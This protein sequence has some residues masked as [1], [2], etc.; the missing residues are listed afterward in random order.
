MVS[1]IHHKWTEG[2]INWLWREVKDVEEL[3][4]DVRTEA[5]GWVRTML[6]LSMEYGLKAYVGADRYQRADSRNTYRN[7]YYERD[8]ET[9]LGLIKDI[10]VPRA[11]NGGYRPTE[12]FQRYKRRQEGVNR[13]LREMFLGGISTRR[14]GEVLETLLGYRLSA[15]TVSQATKEL[16]GEIRKYHNRPLTERYKF[17]LLDGVVLRIKGPERYR[18]RVILCAYGITASRRR[19]LIDFMP[20]RGETEAEWSSFLNSLYRR[21]L[22]GEGLEL[23]VIDGG[24]GLV[25]ALDMV[26]PFIPRQRC[27]V[28]KLRNIANYVRRKDRKEVLAGA[29]K[30]YQAD[31]K[32][33]S[34][35]KYRQWANR[36]RGPYPKA[37]DC[38][39]KDLEALLRF[40]DFS[41]EYR[42]T[43]RTT[44]PIER[45]FRE[46][47]RRTRPISCFNDTRSCERIV[48]GVFSYL[49]KK[50]KAH[51]IKDFNFTQ[52]S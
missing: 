3:W 40:L 4:G 52:F 18:K 51:P 24:R 12:V 37:V 49:N 6:G 33:E 23:I 11:R 26:Y 45:A 31:N 5:L 36:W 10:A 46:V 20:A 44:N 27:W 32:Q 28:H 14:V 22:K 2:S 30:I 9:E 47:R 17:L 19:E 7:G 15:Q 29:R 39:E 42:K 1:T 35:K 50:W 8:L 13:T 41:V 48:F 34:L 21:G 16:D 43:I 25:A 38:L